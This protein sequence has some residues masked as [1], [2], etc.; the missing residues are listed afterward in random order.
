MDEALR[1]LIDVEAIKA[2]HIRYCHGVDRCDW[3]LVRSCYHPDAIDD[4]GDY[5][6]GIDGFIDYCKGGVPNF[7]ST[8]H[9]TG[10]QLVE[11][12]G[13]TAWA[14][15]YARAYH[16]LAASGDNPAVDLVANVRYAD[17]LERRDGEWR[18]AKRV[19]IIDAEGTV[20]AGDAW[21]PAVLKRGKRDRSDPSYQR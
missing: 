12:D 20:P 8:S 9:F 13:D 1:R 2:L 14:E 19:V 4:H 15:H 7:E 16:R 6:G 10:N 3:D 17:R 5:V 18:F 21:A 11:V